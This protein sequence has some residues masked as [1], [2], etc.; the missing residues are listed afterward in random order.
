M[1]KVVRVTGVALM[2]AA[3]VAAG[4]CG[5]SEAEKQAEET[6]A[7]LEKAAKDAEAAGKSDGPGGHATPRRGWNSSPRASKA[8]PARWRAPRARTA[9]RSNR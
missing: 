2:L 6:R 5:K 7:A 4:A 1:V 9:S 3:A 8:W